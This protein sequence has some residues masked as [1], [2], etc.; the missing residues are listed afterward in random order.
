MLFGR[1]GIDGRSGWADAD[2]AS[3][4]EL[5]S[6]SAVIWRLWSYG[7][8]GHILGLL[9]ADKVASVAQYRPWPPWPITH[10]GLLGVAL[11][12]PRACH[13]H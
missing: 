4:G 3:N 8:L 6:R 5:L 11:I 10:A 1:A 2:M 7:L 12:S 9:T 13:F